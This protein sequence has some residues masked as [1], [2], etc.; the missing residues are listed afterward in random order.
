MVGCDPFEFFPDLPGSDAALD[1]EGLDV[2][3]AFTSVTQADMDMGKEMIT[4]IKQDAGCC[5]A[6]KDRH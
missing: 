6:L 3:R 5:K 4:G 2:D 1:R